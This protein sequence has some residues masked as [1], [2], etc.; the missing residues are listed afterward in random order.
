MTKQTPDRAAP[1]NQPS[2]VEPDKNASR[3]AT[4]AVPSR[5]EE[6]S[7]VAILGYN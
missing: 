1:T 7:H 3:R 6:L 4:V 2:N 5:E